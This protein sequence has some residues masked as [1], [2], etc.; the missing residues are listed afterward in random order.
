MSNRN[1]SRRLLP[2]LALLTLLTGPALLLAADPPSF[3]GNWVLNTKKGENLPMGGAVAETVT[4]AQTAKSMTLDFTYVFMG[5]TTLN[6]VTYDFSGKTV[7][8]AGPMGDKA[9]TVAKWAGGKLVVVWTGESAILGNK[10]EKTESRELAADGKT[11]TVT[12]T[13]GTK[14]PMITVYERQK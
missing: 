12:T 6:K 9:D 14:P 5:K 7:Q 8:N 11:M 10:T 4:I 2:A 13:R 1:V 3:A